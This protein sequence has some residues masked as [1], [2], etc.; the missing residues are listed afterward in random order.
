MITSEIKINGTL[1]GHVYCTNTLE[2]NKKKEY[3]YNVTVYD[4]VSNTG[5]SFSV[6]HDR[7]KTYGKLMR[8]IWSK[9]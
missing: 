9:V 2:Q 3:K 7:K 8:K 5:K 1:I 4:V 6:W